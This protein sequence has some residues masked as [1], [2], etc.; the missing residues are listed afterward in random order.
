MGYNCMLVIKSSNYLITLITPGRG[1]G[2][3]YYNLT[4]L[5]QETIWI[6][7]TFNPCGII[8][9]SQLSI[10][11]ILQFDKKAVFWKGGGAKICKTKHSQYK[12]LFY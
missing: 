10:K 12:I 8:S 4:S 7:T 6:Q 2:P 11:N 5:K 3:W 1:G 9:V